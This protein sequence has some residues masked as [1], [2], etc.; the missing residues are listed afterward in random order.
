MRGE[1]TVEVVTADRE[2]I[3]AVGA[4]V[5]AGTAAGDPAAAPAGIGDAAGRLPLTIESARPFRGGLIVKLDAIPDRTAAA[6]WR[7][8]YLLVPAGEL[9]PPA[10]DEVFVHELVGLEVVAEDGRPLGSVEAFYDLPQGLTLEVRTAG[11][12]GV[13]VPYRPQFVRAVD[14]AAGTLTVDA[15]S[16]LFE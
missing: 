4:R 15:G 10:A 11:A 1:V 12:G 16:G 6:R 13:L 2:R 8:R 7:G 5:Y 9:T 3:F 14:L